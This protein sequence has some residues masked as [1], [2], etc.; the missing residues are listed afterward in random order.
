MSILTIRA[1]TDGRAFDPDE[2]NALRFDLEREVGEVQLPAPTG[3]G[4]KGPELDLVTIAVAVL[5][6]PA[7]T[8]LIGLL[9][10]R[11]ERDD[12]TEFVLEGPGGKVTFKGR[13][14]SLVS[15]ADF[16]RLI[17]RVLAGESK[18][19][20]NASSGPGSSQPV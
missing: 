15:S 8:A 5:S 17:E 20:G 12:S 11:L 13:D 6:A 14:R 19:V 7:I 10:A 9:K 1:S 3:V 4:A 16:S 2:T 18:G